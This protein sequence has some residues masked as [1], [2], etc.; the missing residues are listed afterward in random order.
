MKKLDIK[1]F[2]ILLCSLLLC[3]YSSKV[4]AQTVENS[5]GYKMIP[6]Q[7]WGQLRSNSLQLELKL[8]EVKLQ[9]EM[10]SEQSNEVKA[11]LMEAEKQ[12]M[13]SKQELENSNLSLASAK[14]LQQK[15]RESLTELTNQIEAER[16]KNQQIQDKLRVQRTIAWI[17]AGL[18]FVS[19]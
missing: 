12:L 17:V 7:Q 14:D 5:T 15:A 4:S 9:L 2:L 1:F 16:E 13:I 19:K 18:F 10:L 6:I 3:A 8:E 11:K